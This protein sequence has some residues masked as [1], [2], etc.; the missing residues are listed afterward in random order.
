MHDVIEATDAVL[1]SGTF[2]C[3]MRCLLQFGNYCNWSPHNPNET[4]R[5]STALLYVRQDHVSYE[6]IDQKVGSVK[7][8]ATSAEGS[9]GACYV[10]RELPYMDISASIPLPP[11]VYR[12]SGTGSSVDRKPYRGD[13]YIGRGV[14]NE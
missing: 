8:S 3:I 10:I 14:V 13:A 11:G 1:Q 9:C 4:Q 2:R 6:K 12:P 7:R 5:A